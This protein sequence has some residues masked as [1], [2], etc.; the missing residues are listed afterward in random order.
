MTLKH[1]REQTEI[2][3]NELAVDPNQVTLYM[4][5]IKEKYIHHKYNAES[6]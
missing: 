4:K 6:A 1:I 2:K 3:S 5:I